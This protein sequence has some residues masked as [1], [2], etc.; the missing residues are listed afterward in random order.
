MSRVTLLQKNYLTEF[1]I[2]FV[3]PW[4]VNLFFT[5]DVRIFRVIHQQLQ[6]HEDLIQMELWCNRNSMQLN[7]YKCQV[8]PFHF[9]PHCSMQDELTV[10]KDLDLN[11]KPPQ[12]K[13]YILLP[14]I[15]AKANSVLGFISCTSKNTLSSCTIKTLFR[16]IL[17]NMALPLGT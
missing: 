17:E 2:I 9:Y 10:V 4:S 11:M 14:T 12:I 6:L 16:P 13:V 8:M 5:D 7:A 3:G 15:C 1:K